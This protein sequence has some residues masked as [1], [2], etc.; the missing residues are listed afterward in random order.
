[1]AWTAP[2]TAVAGSIYT[3]AQFNTFVR[4]NLNETAPAKATTAGSYFVT[5]GTNQIAE[6][7]IGQA[8][9]TTGDSS[10]QTSYADCTD[11]VPTGGSP[12][13]GPAVTVFTGSTALVVVGG[14]I[15]G[16]TVSTQ[17]VKMSW[18]V[19]GASSI[20]AADTWAAG[21]VGFTSSGFAYDSRA[22]LCT[23]LTQGLNTFTAKYS[24]SSG[25]GQFSNRTILVM[26]F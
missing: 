4:D 1:M 12:T 5:S 17:S 16:G 26:P 3:A 18:Q 25:I 21:V 11:T 10:D 8:Q 14:R 6:R 2:M 19:D 24:V 22:Y 23:G 9:V 15:G 13:P 20:A 7:V